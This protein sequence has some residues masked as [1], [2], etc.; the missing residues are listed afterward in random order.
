MFLNREM[1]KQI[2]AQPYSRVKKRNTSLVN[3]KNIMLTKRSQT[4]KSTDCITPF[5]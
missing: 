1:D 5:K 2:V 3:L 4:L